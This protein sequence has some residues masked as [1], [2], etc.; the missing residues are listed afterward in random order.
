MSIVQD[1]KFWCD[2]H[3]MPPLASLLVFLKTLSRF[4]IKRRGDKTDPSINSN[5]ALESN[6]DCM[7]IEST[8]SMFKVVEQHVKREEF[9]HS[10]Q[11]FRL[12]PLY[13]LCSVVLRTGATHS[14]MIK[15]RTLFTAIKRLIPIQFLQRLRSAFFGIEKLR[16]PFFGI[17]RMRRPFFGIDKISS[18]FQTLGIILV[19]HI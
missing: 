1:A 10:T 17:E 15:A 19:F 4:T 12:K 11:S 13:S 16:C 14:N 9:M 5:L 3:W 6:P 2:R 8:E 18:S 7:L